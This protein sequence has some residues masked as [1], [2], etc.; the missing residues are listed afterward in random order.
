[1]LILPV[2]VKEVGALNIEKFFD[3]Q[4]MSIHLKENVIPLAKKGKPGAWS[5]T[6]L[7]DNVLSAH[8]IRNFASDIIEKT[9]LS[10]GAFI[11]ISGLGL[12]VVQFKNYR[13]VIAKPPF[14]DGW[15]LTAVRP[16]A[17]L[18]IDNYTL[19]QKLLQRLKITATGILI[20]GAP[21]SGKTTFA[22]AL[23]KF[24][25]KQGKI[26]KTIESPRDLQVPDA[27]TQYSKNLGTRDD[28]HNVMLLTRP[29]YTI[30]DEMRTTEDF[31][32]YADLRLA[33]IG[34]AGVVHATGPI[35]AVQRFVGR[36]ELGMI[37]QVFDTIVFIK[38]GQV[39]EI[40]D[41]VMKVKMPT[42][43]M[44][45]DLARPVVEVR[46][47]ETGELQFEM[48]VYGEQTVVIPVRKRVK[49]KSDIASEE[50][51]AESL[52]KK[53]GFP[54]KVEQMDEGHYALYVPQG[55]EAKVIGRKGER[56]SKLEQDIGVHIDVRT[57]EE[58]SGL[59]LDFKA[60]EEKKF[61]SF[62]FSEPVKSVALQIEGK[63]LATLPVDRAG[64]IKLHKKSKLGRQVAEALHEGLHMDFIATG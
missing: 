45:A 31:K 60:K 10:E 52:R 33:G 17:S 16:I 11:E 47:F 46:D 56:I 54:I 41:L 14:S 29:D 50:N 51:I 32:L 30:F 13:I 26:V 39:N 3:G 2:S 1:M 55:N 48:Y 9:K 28:I 4:T 58:V 44:E 57:L 53:L 15:E 64:Q 12:T 35:D 59:K 38:D 49:T 63:E 23:A 42:G 7:Q 21:G 6:N 20:A 61:I 34:L 43:M 22:A 62:Y 19:S 40:L 24:Y 37:P 18:E 8:E 25:L 5:F 27:I 36:I